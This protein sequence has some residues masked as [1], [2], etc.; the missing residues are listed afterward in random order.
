MQKTVIILL[1]TLF[2]GCHSIN[3]D[4]LPGNSIDELDTFIVDR[5]ELSKKPGLSLIVTQGEDVILKK[6]YGYRDIGK[7]LN[8]EEDTPFT[9]SSVSKLIVGVAV[10]QLNESNKIDLNE[11]IND[12]IDFNVSNPNFPEK[13]ITVKMLLNHSAGLKMNFP[14]LCFTKN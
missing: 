10:M 3:Y 2:L 6:Q 14:R 12:Y 5:M 8:V 13:T 1:T 7:K 4:K 9:I 11:D